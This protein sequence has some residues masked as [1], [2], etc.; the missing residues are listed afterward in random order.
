MLS[1][2]HI[3]HAGNFAD[4]VKHV[5]LVRLLFALRRKETPFCVLDTHAGTGRYDLLSDEAQKNREFAD[6][7]LRVLDCPDRP[8]AVTDYLTL[9]SA[10]NGGSDDLTYYPGSP[11]L[12]RALLRPGDR[13]ILS[14]LHRADHAQLKQLFAGDTQVA[15]HRQDAY[16]SLKAFLPPKEKRGLVLIDPPYERKDEYDRVAAAL[17]TAYARWPTGVFAVWYPVMSR[18]LVRRFH[19]AVAAT[20]LRKIL[21]VELCREDEAARREFI[22]TGLLIVNPPW[23]LQ[24]ELEPVLSWLW[25]CLSHNAGGMAVVDWL[26]PE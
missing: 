22:G 26:V 25:N 11:C 14:E 17:Q 23:P 9:V 15:V 5:V 2:R 7:M 18:S 21:R 3:Y 20:D 10:E 1:Y 8:E 12:I 16:Q 13:L 6:G 19:D 4:V 24:Q